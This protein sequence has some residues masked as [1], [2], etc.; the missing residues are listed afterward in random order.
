MLYPLCYQACKSVRVSV[1]KQIGP[2]R[3]HQGPH[4]VHKV[5]YLLGCGD[6]LSFGFEN[7]FLISLLVDIVE[8]ISWFLML[9]LLLL[10]LMLLLMCLTVIFD[11]SS[12]YYV[13]NRELPDNKTSINFD[14]FPIFIITCL[15]VYISD[16]ICSPWSLFQERRSSG[17]FPEY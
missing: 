3:V 8:D 14:L 4:R 15:F 5:E 11:E 7:I 13:F 10:L 16:S 2:Q 1:C 12:S 9:L 17:T 6:V